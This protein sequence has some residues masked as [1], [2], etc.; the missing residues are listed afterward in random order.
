M[1]QNNTEN[2]DNGE[3]KQRTKVSSLE[4]AIKVLN[5]F[6]VR[7]KLGVT[8]I[9][10]MLGLYKSN[11]HNILSTYEAMGYLEQDEDTGKYKLGLG[12]FT[13]SRALG[14]S[15][16]ITKV[17]VPYMQALANQTKEKVYLG[18]PHAD[19]VVYLEAMY[20]AGEMSMMRSLLGERAKM[21]CT[22]I[23]KAM[24]AFLPE[25]ERDIYCRGPFE[26]FTEQTITTEERLIKELEKIR[27][28]G[29]SVDQME[30][31]YGIKCIGVPVFDKN[32]SVCAAISISGPS[33]R[34]T[35][36]RITELYSLL[37]ENIRII[38][39]RI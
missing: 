17:A 31:E 25:P 6:T 34:F 28:Q 19:E 15:F 21:Y 35:D 29:Y 3:K 27:R 10:S 2:R 4:K 37:S 5:C 39:T 30:H 20:P 7:P 9:S 32:G 18:I 24:M 8:E 13:L 1:S 33:L 23:G 38:E 26:A 36:E 22:G 14:D 12:I 11:V 16:S